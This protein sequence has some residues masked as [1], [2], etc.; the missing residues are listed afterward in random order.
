MQSLIML[1][2]GGLSV[3]GIVN[4]NDSLQTVYEDRT[5]PMSQL[6]E[7]Q[8]LQML[9]RILLI[10]SLTET[11][12][13]VIAKNTTLFESYLKKAAEKLLRDAG[14]SIQKKITTF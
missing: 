2:I 5:I 7:M 8:K 1:G 4:V 10:S 12:P 9:N 13:A 6:A 11:A 14:P 3:N